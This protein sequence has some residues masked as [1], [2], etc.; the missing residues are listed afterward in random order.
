MKWMN[1][2]DE[3]GKPFKGRKGILDVKPYNIKKLVGTH[4]LES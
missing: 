1:V 4:F 3:N 2:F